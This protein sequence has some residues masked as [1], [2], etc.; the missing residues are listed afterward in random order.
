M[1][2]EKVIQIAV[3]STPGSRDVANHDDMHR[4]STLIALTDQG[5]IFYCEN[6]V[7]FFAGWKQITGLDNLLNKGDEQ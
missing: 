4:R 2:S 7:D 3:A 1:K 6:N 5:R